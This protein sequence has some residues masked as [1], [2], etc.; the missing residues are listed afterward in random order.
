MA[1]ALR[2]GLILVAAASAAPF[3]YAHADLDTQ[4]HDATHRI[5]SHPEDAR[6]WLHRA[7]LYRLRGAW[8]DA[9]RDYRRAAELDPRL[10]AVDL[11]R[12]RML[13]DAGR[14]S[15]A[16]PYLDRFVR[17]R[18][19]FVDG[20]VARARA[21]LAAGDPRGAVADWDA[22]IRS[23]GE[24]DGRPEYYL[25]RADAM[26]AVDP[27]ARARAVDGL[28]EGY[29][30]LG[31]AVA[32]KARIRDL[33]PKRNLPA[34]VA[35]ED[36]P[37]QAVPALL[38]TLARGP[39]LQLG[40]PTSVVVRWRSHPATDGV[41]RYGIAPGAL[42]ST[43]TQTTV[44]SDHVVQVSGLLPSTRYYYSIGS[45]TETLAGG[46]S[47]FS[48]VTAPA[49]GTTRPFRTWVL[50]DS[51]TANPNAA[52][53]RN[54]YTTFTGT[55]PTDLW[56][57]LGDNAY[58]NGTDTEYQAAVFNMYTVM[59]RQSVLWSC[60]G[61]HDGQSADSDT[62]TGA[63]Y[64]MFTFPKSGE[65]GGVP[66]GTEAY[67]S[68]DFGNVHFVSLDSFESSRSPSGAML[69]WLANDLG[70]TTKDWIIAFWHHPPYSRG[71]HN[72]DIEAELTDMRVNA[73]PILEAHGV[74]LV[75]TGHTH[76]Y[77]R[78][79]LIDGHYG[80]SGTFSPLHVKDGGSGR[81][82]TDGPYEKPL[83]GPDP[84]EGTVY[85]VAGSSGQISGGT[86]NHPAKYLSLNVLGSMVL[87]FNGNRL[88]A[89][90]LDSTGTV[91]DTFTIVK[92]PTLLPQTDFDGS[93]RTGPAPL[94]VQ[95]SDKTL[96]GPTAWSW[97]TDGNGT[98]DATTQ[99]PS[100]MYPAAGRYTVS[101]AAT[102]LGGTQPAT[103][104]GFVCVTA[105]APP[106]AVTGLMLGPDKSALSWGAPALDASFDLVR[107]DLG[108]LRSGDGN[109]TTSSTTCVEN[110]GGDGIGS[111]ASSPAPGGG[112]WYVV[113]A[114]DC[115]NR[116]GS[117]DDGTQ[118][119]S[120]DAE[121]AAAATAC[122]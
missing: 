68:F 36:P 55:R 8:A 98:P 2:I 112:F 101:L 3:A 113:R 57:M 87:D 97:D 110:D 54:A 27:K 82:A 17:A 61:N 119:G 80:A 76:A 117:Y 35:E 44:A 49:I 69:T 122:P 32:L 84:H 83:V 33:D 39:Y 60:Y 72:S 15:E 65:A 11:G 109:F 111:D 102:N 42:T 18:P 7:E 20:H 51:G 46:T 5:E 73:N 88:D 95:F 6:A 34:I 9:E 89:T 59:L 30:L 79:F 19:G 12:G 77:E 14:P 10:E 47:D 99:N 29:R 26:L 75:L 121:I 56:L 67:Y 115:A 41:V 31:G 86:L 70:A 116:A 1:G 104:T 108:A 22:A 92:Q 25:E 28:V 64:D 23:A 118:S 74:D 21:R 106:A 94:T 103:K 40:T 24:E 58:P 16:L 52:A 13:T 114:A 93:P 48:F 71:S 96:N 81:P 100:L 66:S 78:S 38:A 120:R 53:V 105:A 62:Q 50:G 63:Y 43:A 37:V 91:R 4:L 90:Y 85:T 107:G 45:S